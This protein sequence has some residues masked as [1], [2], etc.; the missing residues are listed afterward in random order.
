MHNK[1]GEFCQGV[2]KLPSNSPKKKPNP[3]SHRQVTS[4]NSTYMLHVL[5]MH[6][7]FSQIQKCRN[8]RVEETGKKQRYED[9]AGPI[10]R[11][12]NMKQKHSTPYINRSRIDNNKPSCGLKA[13]GN[14]SCQI[15]RYNISCNGK[16]TVL[17]R[18]NEHRKK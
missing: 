10:R 5:C 7:N 12:L 14:N 2:R 17:A 8:E 11:Q 15:I 13:N 4:H 1:C 3:M 18:R 9:V 16:R 6:T